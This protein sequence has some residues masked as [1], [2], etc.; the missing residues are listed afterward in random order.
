MSSREEQRNITAGTYKHQKEIP[1]DRAYCEVMMYCVDTNLWGPGPL[2]VCK[3]GPYNKRVQ[4][5]QVGRVVEE[6]EFCILSD[7]DIKLNPEVLLS[8]PIGLARLRAY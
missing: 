1:I 4:R 2:R 3:R 5:T 8:V 7:S 6:G